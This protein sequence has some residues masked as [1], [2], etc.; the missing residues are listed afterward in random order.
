LFFYAGDGDEPPH[1]HV[2]RDDGVAKFWLAPVRLQRAAGLRASE[3][4]QIER[5]VEE[6]ETRLLEAW[7]DYF[8]R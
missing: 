5:L 6:Q 8:D 1:V 2:E 3:V 4:R 7:N